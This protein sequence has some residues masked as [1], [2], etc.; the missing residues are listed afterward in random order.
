MLLLG[1]ST[2]L[3]KIYIHINMNFINWLEETSNEHLSHLF[4]PIGKNPSIGPEVIDKRSTPEIVIYRSPHGSYRLIYQFNGMPASALQIVI[5]NNEAHVANVYTKPE[6]RRSG[7]ATK[8]LNKV[9]TMFKNVS[10]SR[11]RSDDGSNW[12]KAVS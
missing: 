7:L 6:F 8:L 12:V 4:Q 11:H 3:I 10:F 5:M 1:K 9:K 2:I